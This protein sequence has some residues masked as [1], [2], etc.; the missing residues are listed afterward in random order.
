MG[1]YDS[2][3]QGRGHVAC[4]VIF[5]RDGT[6]ATQLT[7]AVYQPGTAPV[8]RT[9]VRQALRGT[10]SNVSAMSWKLGLA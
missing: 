9:Y 10:V 8:K 7:M 1:A 6:R 3:D 4:A 2:L 5:L